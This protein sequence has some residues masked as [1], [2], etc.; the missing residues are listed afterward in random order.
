MFK[1]SENSLWSPWLFAYRHFI[2]QIG[3]IFS[4][5]SVYLLIYLFFLFLTN[6]TSYFQYHANYS[7]NTENVL[8]S[9]ERAINVG[10]F[11]KCGERWR[12]WSD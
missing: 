2:P 7:E 8:R 4:A 12:Q 9:F 11:D 1:N 6:F 3:K 10:D 5:R